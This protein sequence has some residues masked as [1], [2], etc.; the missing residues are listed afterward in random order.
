MNG[1]ER[2]GFIGTIGRLQKS[3]EW[4]EQVLI[5]LNNRAI[6]LVIER[7][8]RFLEQTRFGSTKEINLE[9]MFREISRAFELPRHRRTETLLSLGLNESEASRFSEEYD[10]ALGSIDEDPDHYIDKMTLIL[11]NTFLSS[12][13][14]YIAEGIANNIRS[15]KGKITRRQFLKRTTITGGALLLARFGLLPVLDPEI[16]ASLPAAYSRPKVEPVTIQPE[17]R[18]LDDLEYKE[19]YDRFITSR[20]REE[21]LTFEHWL[22][23]TKR[24]TYLAKHYYLTEIRQ[25]QSFYNYF[26]HFI[27]SI[28]EIC[29]SVNL[30]FVL[31]INLLSYS[32]ATQYNYDIYSKDVD[33][34]RV[35]V[36]ASAFADHFRAGTMLKDILS[37]SRGLKGRIAR[38][39]HADLPMDL[40]STVR[41]LG[42]ATIGINDLELAIMAEAFYSEQRTLQTSMLGLRQQLEADHPEQMKSLSALQREREKLE[43]IRRELHQTSCEYL[44]RF[45]DSLEIFLSPDTS[46]E[47]FKEIGIIVPIDPWQKTN[48]TIAWVKY[49]EALDSPANAIRDSVRVEFDV[50]EATR[51]HFT[52]DLFNFVENPNLDRN[53]VYRALLHD[54]ILNSEFTRYL[55]RLA[56]SPEE[57]K[58]IMKIEECRKRFKRQGDRVAIAEKRSMATIGKLEFDM[59][60]QLQTGIATLQGLNLKVQEKFGPVNAEDWNSLAFHTM[61]TLGIREVPN[62]QLIATNLFARDCRI[63]APYDHNGFLDALSDWISILRT[64]E[65]QRVNPTTNFSPFIHVY[66]R[67]RNKQSEGYDETDWAR[68]AY[69]YKTRIGGTC[70]SLG[71]AYAQRF[72]RSHQGD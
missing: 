62:L 63:D 17:I 5:P 3:L 46:R 59:Q 47:A 55:R 42:P 13:S 18:E 7:T 53:L 10:E 45:G 66:S 69:L 22:E 56:D 44:D 1:K 29:E 6:N 31:L 23:I 4:K 33:I 43:V 27:E 51:R 19:L 12:I 37:S 67:V 41:I 24:L 54:Q 68:M 39:L 30:E 71:T 40:Y 8:K 38:F 72:H 2:G 9:D 57:K 50:V 15:Q 28:T 36:L 58:A 52:S 25:D 14:L 21:V 35:R 48:T 26:T 11:W 16:R 61:A 32:A 64:P 20:G 34:E 60:F 70:F 49:A 65:G